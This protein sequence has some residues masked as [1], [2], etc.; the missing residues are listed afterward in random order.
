MKEKNALAI[1]ARTIEMLIGLDDGNAAKKT[2]NPDG[3]PRKMATYAV[4]VD[5]K[6]A[7]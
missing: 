1:T 4:S 7:A 3:V 5:H 2:S 6:A